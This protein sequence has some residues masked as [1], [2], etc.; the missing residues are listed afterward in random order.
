MSE[1]IELRIEQRLPDIES[2]PAMDAATL[3]GSMADKIST[4]IGEAHRLNTSRLT[5]E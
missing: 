4:S 2:R 5:E 3:R 1:T